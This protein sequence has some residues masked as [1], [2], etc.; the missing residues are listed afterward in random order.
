MNNTEEINRT[1]KNCKYYAAHYVIS[2]LHL[3]RT[4]SGHC[5]NS[6]LNKQVRKNSHVTQ[7]N[8]S[9]WE[10]DKSKK[11]EKVKNAEEALLVI[12]RHLR[13]IKNILK[14]ITK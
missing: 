6:D 10:S 14:E 12:E 7:S 5:V 11:E 13:D 3:S 1:C 2:G 8:C 9:F 4:D